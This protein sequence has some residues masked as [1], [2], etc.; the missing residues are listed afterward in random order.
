MSWCSLSSLQLVSLIASHQKKNWNC[1]AII[2][3]QTRHS[4]STLLS[5]VYGIDQ[6]VGP[7]LEEVKTVGEQQK[8]FSHE[9]KQT[10]QQP[11]HKSLVAACFG[12]F[13]LDWILYNYQ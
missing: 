5:A 2:V 13:G 3:F 1:N 8:N 10:T 12:G 4:T 6:H 11:I 9:L 7:S